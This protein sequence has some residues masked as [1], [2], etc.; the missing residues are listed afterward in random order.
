VVVAAIAVLLHVFVRQID[1]VAVAVAVVV[2]WLVALAQA[3]M[4]PVRAAECASWADR[5]LGGESAYETYLEHRDAGGD[6]PAMQRLVAWIDSGARRSAERLASLPDDLHLRKPCAVAAVALL[7]AIVLLQVPIQTTASSSRTQAAAAGNGAASEREHGDSGAARTADLVAGNE[8]TSSLTSDRGD[9]ASRDLERTPAAAGV[10]RVDSETREA[11]G[12]MNAGPA[13]EQAA[14]GGR[15]AGK[16]ADTLADTGLT[17]A[18]QGEMATKL[19]ELA[20]ADQQPS[21]A[22]PALA[23]DYQPATTRQ[24][25]AAAAIAFEPAAAVAPEARSRM[26]LGPAEQAYVRS[27]FADSGATP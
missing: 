13:A 7:L 6:A 16:T 25:S 23:A 5:H 2:T 1:V 22:D 27:Y 10:P 18:W 14:A 8:S 9:T 3:F 17:E 4:R 20:A 21:N 26:R 12:G 11:S 15:D 19:R 24:D